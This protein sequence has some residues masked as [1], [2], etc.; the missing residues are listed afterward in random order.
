MNKVV[1][2]CLCDNILHP[3][4]KKV[5]IETNSAGQIR[6]GTLYGMDKLKEQMLS[7]YNEHGL[8]GWILKCDITKFFYS[9]DHEILKDIV[10]YYFPDSYTTWLNHL[11]IDS[12][13][14][15]GLPLGNQ[16]AQ[17]Y[18][19]LMLDCVDHMITGEPLE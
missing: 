16:V 9:I 19:I 15:V 17:V 14:G 13:D 8:D 11:F 4:L 18:A 3:R 12:T 6:K 2:H 1:Q 10:D 5:F 7:F